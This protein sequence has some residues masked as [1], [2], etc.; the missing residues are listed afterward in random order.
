MTNISFYTLQPTDY[1]LV[2]HCKYKHT[3]ESVAW[4]LAYPIYHVQSMSCV[5]ICYLDLNNQS[6]L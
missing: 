2:Y 3:N 6:I 4:Y 1:T 5:I